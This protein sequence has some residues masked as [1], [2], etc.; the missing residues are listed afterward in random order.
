RSAP[1]IG[2]GVPH[3]H[4]DQAELGI[5][6]DVIP[7]ASAANLVRVA[8]P[9]VGETLARTRNRIESPD[10]LARLR[11]VSTEVSP[12]AVVPAGRPDVPGPVEVAGCRRGVGRRMVRQL[13]LPGDLSRLLIQRH[14]H[15]VA[16]PDVYAAVS[17]GH[18][19]VRADSRFGDGPV[20]PFDLACGGV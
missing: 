4:V 8:F 6:R 13:S 19:L 15:V 16:A 17:D 10:L 2:R 18:P 5:E 20:P 1:D 12:R 14:Q 11:V 7:D 3:A 9:R